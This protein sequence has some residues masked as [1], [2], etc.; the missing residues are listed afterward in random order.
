MDLDSLLN[1]SMSFEDAVNQS[2][3]EGVG[4]WL[5]APFKGAHQ[6][7]TKHGPEAYRRATELGGE[8]GIAGFPAYAAGRLLG[9]GL[10]REEEARLKGLAAKL[11]TAR[12]VE[13]E[14]F[15]KLFEAYRKNVKKA[16]KK[17]AEWL[18]QIEKESDSG[19]TK[20]WQLEYTHFGGKQ[21]PVL[22]LL[23]ADKDEASEK[24]WVKPE[25]EKE[26]SKWTEAP[27]PLAIFNNVVKPVLAAGEK[28]KIP[29][30]LAKAKAQLDG[31]VA[32][33]QSVGDVLPG[34]AT[35]RG[36]WN[37][38][39]DEWE[40]LDRQA[41][42]TEEGAEYGFREFLRQLRRLLQSLG[43][44]VWAMRTAYQELNY[45]YASIGQTLTAA[46]LTGFT[47]VAVPPDRSAQ[48]TKDAKDAEELIRQMRPGQ[49][50]P[51]TVPGGDRFGGKFTTVK[52]GT[53]EEREQAR[54][55]AEQTMTAD[56]MEQFLDA[57]G[58]GRR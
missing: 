24:D 15:N 13:V 18:T 11:S 49:R 21:Y 17:P 26:Q 30:N 9:G 37:M 5:A 33:L 14:E 29:D 10:A 36:K 7:A 28:A 55:D 19:D 47:R 57:T 23:N 16:L 34:A 44:I 41:M 51:S 45:I 31:M 2:V 50:L 6:L 27:K 54:K 38:V 4:D 1:E 56:E 32:F 25:E 42:L 58:T 35:L 48:V 43:R 20:G 12:Q 53:P 8:A 52:G 22:V 39:I 3:E 46:Q 40:Q